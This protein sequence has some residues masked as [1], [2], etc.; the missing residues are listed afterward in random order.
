[1]ARQLPV[2]VQPARVI[3]YVEPATDAEL[4]YYTRAQ[5]A[6]RRQ[7]QQWLYARWQRRQAEISVRDRKLRRFWLGFGLILGLA[8]LT[9]LGVA[10]WLV[11]QFLAG[12]GLGVLVVPVV[13]AGLLV[14][15]LG[16]H[17]CVTVVQHW[18]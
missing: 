10:G 7:E 12:L 1:M 4:A 3:H 9:A 13:L 14:A 11:W 8:V 2:P 5:L 15:G 16:G 18:H 6:A 17:R